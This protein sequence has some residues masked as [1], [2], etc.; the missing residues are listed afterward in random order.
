M[1]EPSF[2]KDQGGNRGHVHQYGVED[3]GGVEEDW[4]QRG[5]CGGMCGDLSNVVLSQGRGPRSGSKSL[6][7]GRSSVRWVLTGICMLM[8]RL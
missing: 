7:F 2:L 6:S 5:C 8:L 4:C 3:D 1:L